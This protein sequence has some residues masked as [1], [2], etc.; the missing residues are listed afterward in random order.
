MQA[1]ALVSGI[2]IPIRPTILQKIMQIHS[3]GDPD[4]HQIVQLISTDVSLSTGVLKTVNS[5]LYGMRRQ[6]SSI[7]HAVSLLCVGNVINL[8]MG[9]A[10][11]LEIGG[12]F[13]LLGSPDAEQNC[14]IANLKMAEAISHSLR[15]LSDN[16]E[17]ERLQANVLDYVNVS[18]K[19][20][21]ELREDMGDKLN[22]AA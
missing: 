8:V 21:A 16:P 20:F 10:L 12:R 4:I 1:K 9:I 15:R 3:S 14:L 13:D 2:D 19:E 11:R 6:I 7:Q 17:W 18:P 5:P 22:L